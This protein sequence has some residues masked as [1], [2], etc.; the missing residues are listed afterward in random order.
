MSSRALSRAWI[1][2][3]AFGLVSGVSQAATL[4]PPTVSLKVT[5]AGL[6]LSSDDGAHV[7]LKRLT[8]AARQACG[9][10]A[11]F[12]ALR[13]GL[14]QVCY[15]RA[16]SHAVLALNQPMVTHLYV[17]QYPREAARYG[18]AAGSYVAGR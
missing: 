12:D 4:D 15:N 2:V 18:I 8:V 17:A 16:L 3:A 6:D 10:E 1:L 13:A 7:M 9:V 11:E 5:S 14:F